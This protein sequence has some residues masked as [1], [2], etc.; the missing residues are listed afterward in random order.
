MHPIRFLTV[1]FTVIFFALYTTAQPG[2]DEF[3]KVTKEVNDWY[4]N[5]SDLA[6]VIGAVCGLLGGLRVYNNWQSGKH[7]I[8]A[9][10]MGWFFSC[11]FLSLV[12]A[13]LKAFFGIH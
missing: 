5:F 6:L 9:Q 2:L 3:E 7:N 12:G 11:L 4:F 1:F 8:D 13:T 10:V